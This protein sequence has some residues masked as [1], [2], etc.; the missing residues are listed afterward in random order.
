M[1]NCVL[2]SRG[3]LDTLQ[4]DA[5]RR[6]SGTAVGLQIFCDGGYRAGQGAAAFVVTAVLPGGHS[7][8]SAHEQPHNLERG[9]F[10][11]VLI[12]A[13]GVFIQGVKSAF[14]AEATALDI[15]TEWLANTPLDS[16]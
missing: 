11:S 1:A 3:D 14:H 13:C 9:R 15:A 4:A 7:P 2:D 12:G 5:F 10:E 8:Q 16:P 6:F